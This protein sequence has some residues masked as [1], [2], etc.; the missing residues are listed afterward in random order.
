MCPQKL[1][2]VWSEY[3]KY[4]PLTIHDFSTGN[5]ER[6]H[7]FCKGIVTTTPS[8]KELTQIFCEQKVMGKSLK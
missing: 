8:L 3:P 6:H 1:H 4:I 2:I 7:D 5:L